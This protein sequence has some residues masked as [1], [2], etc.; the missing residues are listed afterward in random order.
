VQSQVHCADQRIY[1]RGE[2]TSDTSTAL[3]LE[4][5]ASIVENRDAQWLDLAQADRSRRIAGPVVGAQIREVAWS[6]AGNQQLER[7]RQ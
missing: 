2:V 7:R 5:I 1:V 6:G 3:K 4:V